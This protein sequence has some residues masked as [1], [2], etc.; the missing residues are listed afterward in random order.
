MLKVVVLILLINFSSS[1]SHLN[2]TVIKTAS[3]SDPQ[4]GTVNSSVEYIYR[5]SYNTTQLQLSGKLG[6]PPRVKVTST[7]ASIDTPLMVTTRQPKQLLSWKLPLSVETTNAELVYMNTAR[8]L[9]YDILD[10]IILSSYKLEEHENPIVTLATTS[11]ENIDYTLTVDFPK[12]F[13]L[14][15]SVPYHVNISPSE[16]QYFFYN[17][18]APNNPS[19]NSGSNYD[20]VLLTIT[21]N[22]SICTIVSIQNVSCPVFD[23][24]E[25][26]T[27]RGFY[28]TFTTK[29]GITIPKYKFPYGFYIVFVAKADDYDCTR[30]VESSVSVEAAMVERR[31]KQLSLVISPSISYSDYVFAVFVTLGAIGCFYVVFGV[32][33]CVLSR[34]YYMPRQMEYAEHS[35]SISSRRRVLPIPVEQV[36][37][38]KNIQGSVNPET[39]SLDETE[40]DHIQEIQDD[41]EIRLCRNEPCLNDLARKPPQV[42]VKKSYLY[43]YN[44][45]TVAI[46]YGLPVVQLVITYQRVLNQTGEQDLC[47]YNF[48][49][50]HPMGFLS[51]FNHVFSN[52]GYLSLGILFLII[53]YNRELTHKDLDFDRRYGIPQHY[54][55]FYAMGVAL[56]MEGVLSGSYHVCPSQ[57]NFQ[58]D[59]SFMYV[60]A[61]LCMIKLY[62]NRHPDINASAYSTFG[63][64]AVAILIGM[65]G[66][67][68]NTIEFRICFVVLHIISCFYLSIKM[69]YMGCWKLSISSFVRLGHVIR[70]DFLAGP[71]NVLK[72]CHKARFVMLLIG[73]I[74]NWTLAAIVVTTHPRNFPVF[75][76][77]IFMSNT[78][79]YFFFYIIMKYLH[80]EKVRIITW[81]FLFMSTICAVTAIYFFLHGSIS[82]SKTP[83]QSRTFNTSCKLMHFYDYHDIWHFLSAIGMFFTFMVLLTLDDDLSHTHRNQIPVF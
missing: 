66:I 44:V 70:N 53:T 43:L 24:N 64:L 79:M 41:R 33:F 82:W 21:S 22:D 14:D 13:H 37:L 11:K 9:C 49:C 42:I 71:L 73:N 48:L 40:Y 7:T 16:P 30:G 45:L 52:V 80:K 61:V 8:T 20:T 3:Y 76:L 38:S 17:F 25:D 68:E 5:F 32:T 57:T 50:A 18:S 59:T 19:Q 56:M 29:G 83:A 63:V 47:Y 67:F 35:D 6:V 78:L 51:D 69:Y 4:H 58:F 39:Q 34:K 55:L 77:F 60:M 15:P 23:L 65:I 28:E 2:Y 74:V 36:H 1:I 75:L 54:G 26:I 81:L 12:Y 72:P 31:N 46:F 27:F 62:Q 10:P